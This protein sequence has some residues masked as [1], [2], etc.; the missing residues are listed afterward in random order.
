[1]KKKQKLH[2][3]III[4]SGAAGLMFAAHSAS[5]HN[6]IVF[7][8]DVALES[9]T[10][11]AQGGIAA[12]LNIQDSYGKHIQDTMNAGAGLCDIDAVRVLVWEA[13]A[14]IYDLINMG[15]DFDMADNNALQF[16]REGGHSD[17]RILHVGDM[18]GQAIET[19]LLEKVIAPGNQIAIWDHRM[20]TG[21]IV[22]DNI[23]FG[24]EVINKD[25]EREKIF[26]KTVFLATGGAGQLFSVTTN[27]EIATGDGCVMAYESGAKLENLEFIQFHPTAFH[28]PPAPSF[29]ISESVRGEGGILRNS[30]GERFMTEYHPMAE[31][32]PRDIV[33][34]AIVREMQRL[35][36]DEVFLDLTHL[37]KS[38]IENRFPTIIKMVREYGV[39]PAKEAIPVAPAAHYM[40]GGVKTD[41]DGRSSIQGLY[42]GGEVACT[43]VHG[44][45]RLASN[46]LLE[47]VVFAYR[48]A[49]NADRYIRYLPKSW[50]EK[51]EQVQEIPIRRIVEDDGSNY[52]NEIKEIRRKTQDVMWKYCS[53]RRSNAGLEKGVR[54]IEDL[55]S[56][57][58]KLVKTETNYMPAIEL[59]NLLVLSG[60]VLASAMKRT[61]NA[62]THYN[63]DYDSANLKTK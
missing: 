22:V 19:M 55:K 53:I 5:H 51:L 11:Y 28:H 50:W 15:V 27:P 10:R 30:A 20:V 40:C 57:Y 26:A 16:T 42:A 3:V 23:C 59:R 18:T 34:R 63:I 41:I 47:S 13:P 36:A 4:G 38:Y 25:G 14:R 58:N 29:L 48:S 9:N 1:M 44:A 31:L 12:V 46:S 17:R 24:I 6:I 33:S 39:D 8:K 35:G 60:L 32:A 54:H 62:G 52:E 7:T 21:L 61:I 56:E 2:D 45:N 37:D 43:G 49:V